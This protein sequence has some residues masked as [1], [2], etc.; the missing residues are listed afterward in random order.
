MKAKELVT[1]I[2][3]DV[4][5]ALRE[6]RILH[7][8]T[9]EADSVA[10]NAAVWKGVSKG[11]S[12]LLQEIGERMANLKSTSSQVAA[13]REGFQKWR[14]VVAR[15]KANPY[16]GDHHYVEDLVF[17]IFIKENMG[18]QTLCALDDEH[19]FGGFEFPPSIAKQMSD[20]RLT[21]AAE[22]RYKMGADAFWATVASRVFG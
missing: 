9:D 3:D 8:P 11:I 12:D 20:Y 10:Y 4:S 2:E 13:L 6:A 5:L 7:I 15:L 1:Q 16:F 14:A 22:Q 17:P 21:K 19:V 18:I